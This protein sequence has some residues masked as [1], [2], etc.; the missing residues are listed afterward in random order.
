MRG[1]TR[2]VTSLSGCAGFRLAERPLPAPDDLG[3][4]STGQSHPLPS[5]HGPTRAPTTIVAATALVSARC[6]RLMQ[7]APFTHQRATRLV[8]G[9]T[10][11]LALAT[12]VAVTEPK[13][14]RP[15]ARAATTDDQSATGAWHLPVTPLRLVA[16][17]RAP[18]HPYGSGH[19][20]VD[21]AAGAG[22]TVIAPAAGEVAF[23]GLVADRSVISIAIGPGILVSMEPVVPR[24]D[25]AGRFSPLVST[26]KNTRRQV[27]AGE[28]IGVVGVGGHCAT[29]C[30][31][32]GLRKY[33][34]Y[35]SPLPFLGFRLHSRLLSFQSDRLA[36]PDIAAVRRAGEPG[37]TPR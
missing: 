16:T 36:S 20:G 22:Q 11:V 31:H 4:A 13:P 14:H 6:S 23:S 18:E 2:E 37:D 30:L 9:P 26:N 33:G 7:S 35:L 19:R 15:H 21:F 17:F 3:S 24:A 10:L 12:V 27:V 8:I 25:L 28:A 29:G 1:S 32:L 5:S 34:Q